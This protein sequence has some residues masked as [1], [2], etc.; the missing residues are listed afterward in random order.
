MRKIEQFG[1]SVHRQEL[2]N[3]GTHEGR[4]G[5]TSVCVGVWVWTCGCVGA[6]ARAPADHKKDTIFKNM[7]NAARKNVLHP[8]TSSINKYRRRRNQTGTC[9]DG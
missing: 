8:K 9:G 3:N 5:R 4:E 7:C 6:C 2:A 1:R